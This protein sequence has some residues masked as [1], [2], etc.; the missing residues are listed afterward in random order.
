MISKQIENASLRVISLGA[1]VQ[2]S[3]MAL[4]AARQE[5][6]P[7]PDAAIFADT[8]AEPDAVYEHLNWLESQLPFPVY[9]V[10]AGSLYQAVVTGVQADGHKFN[11]VPFY[12]EGGG[13]G[14]RQ[15]TAIYKIDPVRKKIRDLIGVSKGQKVSAGTTVEQWI[16]ISVDEIV[17]VKDARE[18]WLKNRWPLIEKD[19]RRHDCVNWFAKHYP[20]RHLPRSACYFC[21][22]QRNDEFRRLKDT[23][24]QSWQKAIEVDETIRNAN[25][26]KQQFIHRSCKPL[27]EVDLF[28]AEEKGQMTFLDECDGMCGM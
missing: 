25:E 11:P 13:I 1:G 4:M 20:D 27:S 7:M 23:D 22:Y 26:G 24:P 28:T 16:G 3:V 6:T 2:S 12:I 17:R 5:I 21:P 10:T 19:M 18:G 9:R 15:C 8:Q 14:R